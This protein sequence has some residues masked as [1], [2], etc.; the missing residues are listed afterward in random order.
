MIN[1]K[2]ATETPVLI[3]VTRLILRLLKGRRAT[4]VDRVGLAYLSHYRACCGVQLHAVL[5]WGGRVR[6]MDAALSQKIFDRLLNDARKP[7]DVRFW[8]R[9][10]LRI[11]CLVGYYSY[12]QWKN[13]T[14]TKS[15]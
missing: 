4:G 6:V 3:D 10:L 2:T 7:D 1:E 15:H 14:L 12:R 11:A 8:R 5:S 13:K 9:Q